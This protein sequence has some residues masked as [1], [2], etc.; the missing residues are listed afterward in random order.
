[1]RQIELIDIKTVSKQMTYAE[2]LE[3]ELSDHLTV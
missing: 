3:I 2:L 1:M